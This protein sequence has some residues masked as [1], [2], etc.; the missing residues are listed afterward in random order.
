MP[1]GLRWRAASAAVPVL[2]VGLDMK[3]HA[4]AKHD[5]AVREAAGRLE[6]PAASAEVDGIASVEA[7]A[8]R[9]SPAIAVL[10]AV[11]NAAV[12]EFAAREDA[13]E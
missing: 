13:P 12:V 9:G 10:A 2:S 5:E 8:G 3:A 6:H 1:L 4:D 11:E 7:E